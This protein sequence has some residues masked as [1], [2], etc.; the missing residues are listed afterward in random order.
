MSD[1]DKTGN[2][3]IIHPRRVWSNLQKQ[4]ERSAGAHAADTCNKLHVDLCRPALQ[5]GGFKR[6]NP[7]PVEIAFY[8]FNLLI[9]PLKRKRSLMKTSQCRV[10]LIYE[11]KSVFRSKPPLGLCDKSRK[12]NETQK[13]MKRFHSLFHSGAIDGI[14]ALMQDF[15]K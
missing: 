1:N 9:G 15:D 8:I 3:S 12:Q 6:Q 13:E 7:F 14:D 4:L 2:Y 5:P 11:Q 10:C